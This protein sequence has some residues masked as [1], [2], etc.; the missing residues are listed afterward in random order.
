MNLKMSPAEDVCCM[1]MLTSRSNFGIP[2]NSV[3]PDH[4]A[5]IWVQT[6]CYRYVLKGQADDIQQTIVTIG[7]K[8]FDA[9]TIGIITKT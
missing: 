2:T 6:V 8:R 7:S 4:T 5:L 9:V 1:Y 3:D